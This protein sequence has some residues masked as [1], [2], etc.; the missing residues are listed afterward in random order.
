VKVYFKS[1]VFLSLKTFLSENKALL[2][3]AFLLTAVGFAAGIILTDVDFLDTELKYGGGRV[4]FY[5]FFTLTVC[6]ALVFLAAF[7]KYLVFLA[8]VAFVLLG[9][10]AGQATLLLLA[11][12]LGNLI[13]ILFFYVPITLISVVLLSIAVK[14]VLSYGAGYVCTIM[15]VFKKILYIFAINLGFLLIF[16]LIFVVPFSAPAPVISS[17]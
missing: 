2:L 5:W 15:T 10:R 12:S 6:Y 9:F 11:E 14:T 8:A 7:S 17:E 4:L 16:F 3:L 1:R 13:T